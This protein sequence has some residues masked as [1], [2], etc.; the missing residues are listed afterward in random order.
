MK[1]WLQISQCQKCKTFGVFWCVAPNICQRWSDTGADAGGFAPDTT[2]FKHSQGQ[3]DLYCNSQ[4]RILRHR[5]QL[6]QA[7]KPSGRAKIQLNS[8]RTVSELPDAFKSKSRW[9]RLTHRWHMRWQN[10]AKIV[11]TVSVR[12]TPAL[13]VRTEVCREAQLTPWCRLSAHRT[14]Q[15]GRSHAALPPFQSPGRAVTHA[16][17]PH[18]PTGIN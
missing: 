12:Q 7:F 18:S 2:T 13:T 17:L 4:M 1:F 16:A 3:V 15:D 6:Q 14:L 8:S 5:G 9:C 11:L 10:K